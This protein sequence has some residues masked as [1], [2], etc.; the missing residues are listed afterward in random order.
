M[1]EVVTRCNVLRSKQTGKAQN[2]PEV[3]WQVA[4]AEQPA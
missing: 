4:A 1:R 2:R 3:V